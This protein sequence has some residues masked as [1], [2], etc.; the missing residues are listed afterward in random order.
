MEIFKA[1]KVRIFTKDRTYLNIDGEVKDIE[2]EILFTIKD[3]K[4]SIFVNN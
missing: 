2:K 4:L 1:K 3:E